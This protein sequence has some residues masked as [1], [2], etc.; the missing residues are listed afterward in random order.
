[1]KGKKPS[2]R[3]LYAALDALIDYERE[4]KGATHVNSH[5]YSEVCDALR[6]LIDELESEP[7]SRKREARNAG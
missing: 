2:V 1:M 3:R 7:L 6:G 4:I 5:S